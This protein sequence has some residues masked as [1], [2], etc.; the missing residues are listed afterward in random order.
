MFCGS[1]LNL[2]GERGGKNV[3]FDSKGLK[4]PD[5]CDLREFPRYSISE[6]EKDFSFKG[7]ATMLVLL[8]LFKQ[9]CF[10]SMTYKVHFL[11]QALTVTMI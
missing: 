9:K 2:F 8:H 5:Y 7:L 4:P 11:C 3:S 1:R 10:V 6:N